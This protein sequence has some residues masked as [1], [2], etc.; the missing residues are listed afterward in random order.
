MAK[1]V[2]DGIN[3]EQQS[4]IFRKL[5]VFIN[6]RIW[7]HEYILTQVPGCIANRTKIGETASEWLLKAGVHAAN[8]E[9][10][11]LRVV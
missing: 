6:S 3:T 4:V 5:P 1:F 2:A 7:L 8:K 9:S 11:D 10:M